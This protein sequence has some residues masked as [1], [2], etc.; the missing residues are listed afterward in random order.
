M[1]NLLFVLS[2]VRPELSRSNRL[3][4]VFCQR[5]VELNCGITL[6][7][8]DVGTQPPS[9]PD[10]ANTIANY[11]ALDERTPEMKAALAQSDALIDEI[12]AAD[13]LVFSVPMYNFSVPSLP[14]Y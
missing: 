10:E 13:Y 12:L 9:H 5:F 11:T 14:P 6:V 8:R 3:D 7:Q 4:Q 1:P 2:S